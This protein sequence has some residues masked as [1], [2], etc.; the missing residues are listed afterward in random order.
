VSGEWK[1]KTATLRLCVQ[2]NKEQGVVS[3]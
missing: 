1:I 3:G 2:I